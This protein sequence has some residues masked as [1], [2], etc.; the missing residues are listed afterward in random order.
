MQGS[1]HATSSAN[2]SVS[3]FPTLGRVHA[4]AN[5]RVFFSVEF[6]RVNAR[7]TDIAG[8]NSNMT[9]TGSSASS[10][11]GTL[12]LGIGNTLLGDE[13]IGVHAVRY[14]ARHDA[15]PE[16][17]TYVDGGTLSFTLAG[18]VGEARHLV[19]IDAA[20]LGAVA[21]TVAV[22]E[23]ADMERYLR[24]TRGRSV[25]E[26]SLL[27]LLSV[28]SLTDA[29]PQRLALVGVQP[30]GVD[31]A[32]GLSAPLAGALPEIAR[33]TRALLARWAA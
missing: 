11:H 26:V 31:W 19:V 12:V 15:L 4:R 29:L 33:Q 10:S 28:M 30:Q 32:D 25:H 17:V 8:E 23:D 2:Y 1:V 13:G 9:A 20:E 27:D 22:F 7:V 16:P 18:P 5:T 21:G 24:R 3:A 14:L 6:P